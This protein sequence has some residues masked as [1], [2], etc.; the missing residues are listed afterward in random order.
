[1]GEE[2]IE[3]W[4]GDMQRKFWRKYDNDKGFDSNYWFEFNVSDFP[5]IM[6]DED[7]YKNAIHAKEAKRKL[8]RK[9]RK[10]LQLST[11]R[12]PKKKDDNR[13]LYFRKMEQQKAAELNKL[14]LDNRKAFLRKLLNTD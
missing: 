7:E 6:E 4:I 8:S 14:L 11:K 3:D 1:M 2:G 13:K 12:K 10:Y 9:G 5:N